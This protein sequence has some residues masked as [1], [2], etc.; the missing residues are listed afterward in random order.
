MSK[1]SAR[2]TYQAHTEWLVW[3]KKQYPT[4]RKAKKPQQV[5][6]WFEGYNA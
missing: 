4:L 6:I 3:A 5:P 1:N 2:Q